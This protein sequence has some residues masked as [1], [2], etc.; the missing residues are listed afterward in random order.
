VTHDIGTIQAA[1]AT[2]QANRGALPGDDPFAAARSG[3]NESLLMIDGVPVS[4]VG[5]GRIDGKLSDSLSPNGEQFMA[6]RDLRYDKLVDGDPAVSGAAAMPENPFGGVYG[7]DEGN[8][9]QRD[10][11]LCM[12]KIPGRAA[13]LIDKQFDGESLP[14]KGRAVATSQFDPV[15]AFNHFD[16]PDTEP[17]NP[18]KT[19]IIC[20]PILP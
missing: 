13:A 12:T 10:G 5:N 16:A 2:Y 3:R 20:V 18:D 4:L 7:F 17:Y 11:S 1:V 6:W 15:N 14:N 8:L 9:G 19:Y